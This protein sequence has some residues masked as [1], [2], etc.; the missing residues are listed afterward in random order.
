M[1]EVLIQQS[2]GYAL[3][4]FLTS[5]FFVV[6]YLCLLVIAVSVYS[7]VYAIQNI[8]SPRRGRHVDLEDEEEAL[9]EVERIKQEVLRLAKNSDTVTRP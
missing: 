3:V 6:L 2:W 9:E 8:G 1:I 7:I 4:G 5:I